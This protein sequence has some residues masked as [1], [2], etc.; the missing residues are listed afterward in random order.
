[1]FFKVYEIINLLI[2]ILLILFDCEGY[3]VND[4]C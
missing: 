4:K 2:Y 1:M 3:S